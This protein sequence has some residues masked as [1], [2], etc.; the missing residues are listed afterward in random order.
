MKHL[1]IVGVL[2]VSASNQV[3]A[4]GMEINNRFGPS[5]THT[6]LPA[7]V[8]SF[9]YE[10]TVSGALCPFEIKLWVYVNGMLR[11]YHQEAVGFPVP[12]YQFSCP[13]DMSCWGLQPGDLVT[14]ICRVVDSSTG[15]ILDT[16]YLYGDV[17]SP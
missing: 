17:I 7:N 3:M 12:N 13:I 4:Q 5:G 11:V 6:S 10:A 14:F 15:A 8:Q 2:V 9:D 16:D 1:A